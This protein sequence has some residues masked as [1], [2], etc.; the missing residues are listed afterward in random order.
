MLFML[1]GKGVMHSY[2]NTQKIAPFVHYLLDHREEFSGQEY[3]FVDENPVEL[4]QLILTIKESLRINIPKEIYISYPVAKFCINF[5][6]VLLKGLNKAGVEARLPPEL[7]FMDSFYKTQTLS[8]EKLR[9]T[10][11]GIPDREQT[12]FTELPSIID[13]YITRWGHLNLISSYNVCSY[14]PLKQTELFSKDPNNLLQQIHSGRIE[15]AS[16]F[17]DILNNERKGAV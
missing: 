6:R 17:G 4:R 2:T 5:L 8:T 1:T 10:S 9:Q 15:A 11:Y 13:Y 7:M 16:D 12:I 3:H 14:D